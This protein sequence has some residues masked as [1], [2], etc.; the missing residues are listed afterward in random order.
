MVEQGWWYLAHSYTCKNDKGDYI[1]EGEVANF[2][3]ANIRAARLIDL[4][5]HIYSP[6]SHTHPIHAA[7]P[8]FVG[9]QVHAPWYAYD[10]DFIRTVPFVGIILCPGWEDSSGCRHEKELFEELGRRILFLHEGGV[11]TDERPHA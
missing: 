6:I 7:Y 4:G 2:N 5:W 8:P 3:M 10:N 9:G 1:F 11:V